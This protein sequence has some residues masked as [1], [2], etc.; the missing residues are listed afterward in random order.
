MFD[1]ES[2]CFLNEPYSDFFRIFFFLSILSIFS[3]VANVP[4]L[5]ILNALIART[6]VTYYQY[7]WPE[8]N[9]SASAARGAI[10]YF[11]QNG[12]GLHNAQEFLNVLSRY[13]DANNQTMEEGNNMRRSGENNFFLQR[14]SDVTLSTVPILTEI[15]AYLFPSR[16]SD[17]IQ[18]TRQLETTPNIPLKD[19]RQGW[20]LLLNYW[21]TRGELLN[22]ENNPIEYKCLWVPASA[23][24]S[25]FYGFELIL[26]EVINSVEEAVGVDGAMTQEEADWILFHQLLVQQVILRFCCDRKVDFDERS[27]LQISYEIPALKS[28]FLGDITNQKD[29]AESEVKRKIFEILSE[30]VREPPFPSSL[31][32][33]VCIEESHDESVQKS[34]I[35]EWQDHVCD[36]S[37]SETKDRCSDL[38]DG[39]DKQ[40]QIG[41]QFHDGVLATGKNEDRHHIKEQESDSMTQINQE[42]VVDEPMEVEVIDSEPYSESDEM[43]EK[44]ESEENVDEIGKEEFAVE[45]VDSTDDNEINYNSTA[46]EEYDSIAEEEYNST[47][48]EEYHSDVERENKFDKCKD[49]REKVVDIEEE[50]QDSTYRIEA[51]SESDEEKMCEESLGDSSE[52]SWEENDPIEVD[53]ST[54]DREEVIDDTIHEDN[55]DEQDSHTMESDRDVEIKEQDSKRESNSSYDTSNDYDEARSHVAAPLEEVIDDEESSFHSRSSRKQRNKFFNS[56]PNDIDY[57]GDE[58]REAASSHKSIDESEDSIVSRNESDDES[59]ESVISKD[60][61]IAESGI[62]DVEASIDDSS[63]NVVEETSSGEERHP[64]TVNK[65][66]SVSIEKIVETKD[67]TNTINEKAIETGHTAIKD[68]STTN[69]LNEKEIK[70]SDSPAEDDDTIDASTEKESKTGLPLLKVTDATNVLDEK[71]I[72]AGEDDDT[73]NVLDGKENRRSDSPAEDAEDD[74]TIDVSAEKESKTDFFPVEGTD[75]TNVLDEKE[76]KAGGDDNT[77]NALDEKDSKRSDSPAEDAED[78]DTIDISAEKESKTGSPSVE[79]TDATNVLDEKEIKAGGDDDTTNALDEKDSKRSDS[80]AEGADATNV[81]DENGIE[82]GGDDDATNVLNEN[83]SKTVDSPAE[84]DDTTNALVE[85]KIKTGVSFVED[86]DATNVLAEKEDIQKESREANSSLRE[87][88]ADSLDEK[89]NFQQK[90]ENDDSSTLDEKES[91]K[92]ENRGEGSPIPVEEQHINTLNEKDNILEETNRHD[93]FSEEHQTN[94]SNNIQE[95]RS[96]E[97]KRIQEESK[98]GDSSSGEDGGEDKFQEST[99]DNERALNNNE[100]IKEESKDDVSLSREDGGNH[101]IQE[102]STEHNEI[103]LNEKERIKD[104]SKDDV[105][106]SG[107]DGEEDKF[108]EESKRDNKRALE[109]YERIIEESKNDVSMPEEVGENDNFQEESTVDTTRK[110]STKNQIKEEIKEDASDDYST[111]TYRD[112]QRLCKRRKIKARGKRTALIEDLRNY[113]RQSKKTITIDSE[114]PELKSD[115]QEKVKS[116]LSPVV[117]TGL[118]IAKGLYNMLSPKAK[119]KEP[120]VIDLLGDS[121]DEDE[122]KARIKRESTG[123]ETPKAPKPPSSISFSSPTAMSVI[124]SAPNTSESSATIQSVRSHARAGARVNILPAVTERPPVIGNGPS[125]EAP[126][127]KKTKPKRKAP[128]SN[129]S[130]ASSVSTTRTRKSA[131]LAGRT[132]RTYG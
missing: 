116:I 80:P 8:R 43:E 78:D 71:E 38:N 34:Q 57:E 123:K 63:D 122:A 88:D 50:S 119:K 16:I 87:D 98:K 24:E 45:I 54:I 55:V 48:E 110:L 99:K 86:D 49:G 3:K 31:A 11:L 74:D 112:L 90:S 92:K 52:N 83:E 72:K 42:Y 60:A 96:K 89:D 64:N 27:A 65:L 40:E 53:D 25:I 82:A 105:T 124:S 21:N 70:R 6:L 111:E 23:Y 41:S 91:I 114:Y 1:N 22:A 13:Y 59:Y 7:H 129:E 95:E 35:N 126:L 94:S 30:H 101:K 100:R 130:V 61:S 32:E 128:S 26:K 15:E 115:S 84:D 106:T 47:A 19:K 58:S 37:F 73:T 44:E 14:K 62:A 12:T 51:S 79:G 97:D 9:T 17:A 76:I 10:V 132:R 33:P 118:K 107:Q 69:T 29:V 113:D 46:E 20:L 81:L 120:E 75:A 121:S 109:K 93:S 5:R 18:L 131:R 77:T 104:E 39:V 85:K 4:H 108:Q 117:E 102:E 127:K 36:L 67:D 68:D 2:Q 66:L 125:G 103:A 56:T 28:G